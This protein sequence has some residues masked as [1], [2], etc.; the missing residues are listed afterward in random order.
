MPLIDLLRQLRLFLLLGE[1]GTASKRGQIIKTARMFILNQ[2]SDRPGNGNS[3]F[4]AMNNCKR[5]KPTMR[6][7]TLRTLHDLKPIL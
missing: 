6:V 5:T 7:T 2:L 1:G 3:G 4:R